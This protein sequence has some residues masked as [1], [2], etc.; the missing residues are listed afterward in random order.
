MQTINSKIKNDNVT[1]CRG[2]G[3]KFNPKAFHDHKIKFFETEFLM[4]LQEFFV[5]HNQQLLSYWALYK[6]SLA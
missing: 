3:D 6:G 5:K 2:K 1:S 4:K